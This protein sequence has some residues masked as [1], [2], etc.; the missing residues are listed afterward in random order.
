MSVVACVACGTD[1]T[2]S[3]GGGVCTECKRV[4]YCSTACRDEHWKCGHAFV[5]QQSSWAALGKDGEDRALVEGRFEVS[6]DPNAQFDNKERVRFF[7][8]D[9]GE[10]RGVD[11]LKVIIDRLQIVTTEEGWRLAQDFF[12]SMRIVLL[13]VRSNAH[14]LLIN[15]RAQLT[16]AAD[17]W[18]RLAALDMRAGLGILSN[19]AGPERTLM[20][21]TSLQKWQIARA[22]D[23]KNET[24]ADRIILYL[25][26]REASLEE[27]IKS[28]NVLLGPPVVLEEHDVA[29][30]TNANSP[31]RLRA[32]VI[33]QRIPFQAHPK[34]VDYVRKEPV[35]GLGLDTPLWNPENPGI[36]LLYDWDVDAAIPRNVEIDDAESLPAAFLDINDVSSTVDRVA[37]ARIKWLGEFRSE[38]LQIASLIGLDDIKG[39]IATFIQTLIVNPI[40]AR[41]G[42]MNIAIL[43]EP[44]TGKTEIATRLPQ[45]FYRLGYAPRRYTG[46]ASEV[47]ITTKADWVAP[48]E[49]QSSHQARMTM[50]RG[51]GRMI[52]LDEAYSLVI[53]DADGF[54]KESL[55]QIVNDLDE[56]RGLALLVVLGY[57]NGM[58]ALFAANKGL[59]RRVPNVWTIAP[60]SPLEMVNIILLTATKM[61][62]R[63]SPN[64]AMSRD[65]RELVTALHKQG[66]FASVNAGAAAAILNLYRGIYSR[67]QFSAGMRRVDSPLLEEATLLTAIATYARD[68][69]LYVFEGEDDRDVATPV[70]TRTAGLPRIP[71][72]KESRTPEGLPTLPGPLKGILKKTRQPSPGD[73]PT[74]PLPSDETDSK[75]RDQQQQQPQE[76]KVVK[77]VLPPDPPDTRRRRPSKRQ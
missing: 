6:R 22:R 21:L 70:L 48:Y 64:M 42:F 33:P 54:G 15:T 12:S 3:E 49:G 51:L 55:T 30:A 13:D 68:N 50:L 77:N 39:K 61:D 76:E 60:Y 31:R 75:E 23:D 73:E 1:A 53:D 69:G 4:T 18:A 35:L 11:L 38:L 7:G 44:G 16:E 27:V 62:F 72:Q 20:E 24:G 14:R 59:T 36:Y 43:G 41:R 5:C 17:R 2:T 19:P 8:E 40:S 34:L 47:A 28:T 10:G 9:G 71:P 26:D 57:E 25:L 45:I 29:F 67:Q 66:L 32:G 58:R 52:V 74:P 37:L 56:L 65:L 63:V 46:T